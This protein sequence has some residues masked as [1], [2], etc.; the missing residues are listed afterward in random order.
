MQKRVRGILIDGKTITL[1]KRVKKHEAYFVFPGGGVEKGESARQALKREIKEELGVD[2]KIKK[3]LVKKRFDRPEIEQI[4]YFYL[5]ETIG[6][7]L[8]TGKGPEYQPGNR[9]D[10]THEIAKF[11][12][13]EL[14]NLKL[15]PAEVKDLVLKEF[16]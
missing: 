8:G 4:E 14:K 16:I 11:P 13:N 15:L 9:Y 7:K 10:G 2:I 12:M 5:C 3:L 6:G 1:L